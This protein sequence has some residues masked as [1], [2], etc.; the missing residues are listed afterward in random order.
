MVTTTTTQ[1]MTSR[2]RWL[3]ALDFQPIDR[4]PFWPK[5]TQSYGQAQTTQFQDW[6]IT[7]FHQFIGS[8]PHEWS[9]GCVRSVRPNTDYHCERIGNTRHEVFTTPHGTLERT[10]LFDD[11]SQSWHPTRFPVNNVEDIEL[12]TDW[13]ADEHIELNADALV[14]TK[15]RCASIGEDAVSVH[16]I[17]ESALM[18]WVEH[19]AGIENAH[20]LLADH[21]DETLALFE[22][23]QSNLLRRMQITVEHHPADLLYLTENTSTTLISV[24]QYRQYNWPHLKALADVAAKAGRRL[25][26]HMCGHLKALLDD[27]ERLPTTGFEA[28]TAPTLGNTTLLDGRTHCP[29]KALIG[30][31]HAMIWLEGEQTII[32]FIRERLDELPHHRGIVVTSAGVMPPACPPQ[33]IKAVC[34]W[35]R[36]YPFRL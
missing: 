27:L 19:L 24:D 5:L 11:A 14:N 9:G 34:D 31:T 22:A 10:Y 13:F 23:I 15:N 8:D 2:E 3:A 29:T 7:K 12:L 25:I 4:L 17:G 35:L 32:N 6:S 33:R 16:S 1:Q 36:T 18:I 30:G 28:F 26:L 20:F 21:P